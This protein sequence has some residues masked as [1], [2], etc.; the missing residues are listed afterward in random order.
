MTAY[1]P[2]KNR[3]LYPKRKTRKL[4]ANLIEL[5]HSRFAILV[6]WP[7]YSILHAEVTDGTHGAVESNELREQAT[8]PHQPIAEPGK[9]NERMVD[10]KWGVVMARL[11]RITWWKSRDTR[12]RVELVKSHVTVFETVDWDGWC[13]RGM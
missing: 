13:E 6:G 11:A 10:G 8:R 7:D 3:E 5:S 4:L 12:Y 2:G 9:W 1:L